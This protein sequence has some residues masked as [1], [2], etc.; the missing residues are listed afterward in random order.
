MAIAKTFGAR[1]AGICACVPSTRFDNLTDCVDFS[2]E[3]ISKVTNLAG[4]S[5]RRLAGANVCSSD[6]CTE[7]AKKLL[8]SLGW[9]P[10]SIDA[11]LMVTQTPD[12]FLPSTACVVHKRL[13]L[14]DDCAALDVGLG[15][16]GYPYGLWLASMMIQ[17]A[18]ARRVLLLHGETPARFT[19]NSDRSV[20]LLFGD[21]GSATA[22]EAASPEANT[23]WYYALH[24]DGSA[25]E[26]MIIESGGFRDRFG[27]D[28]RKHCVRMDGALVFNFTIK[29]VPV[30]IDESLNAAGALQGD[31]DYFIFHQSNQYIIK[32]VCSKQRIP[33]NKVPIILKEYGNTGGVSVPLTMTVGALER[34]KDRPLKLLLLGYGV[35][36]SWGSALVDLDHEAILETIECSVSDMAAA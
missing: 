35:G 16:S 18:S 28:P 1:I 5:A 29:R 30:L 19:D 27:A 36:L 8:D 4:V 11:L 13:G 34:P 22:L 3:E 25:Y 24:T 21:A 17:C 7:S 6:L 14:S 33:L 15:C 2:H 32:H 10:S 12:Y 26:A 9:E 20:S 31:I 23:N